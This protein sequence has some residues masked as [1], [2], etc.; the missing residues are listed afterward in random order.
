[1][2]DEDFIKGLHKKKKYK[3]NHQ[4]YIRDEPKIYWFKSKTMLH[5]KIV[6]NKCVIFRKKNNKVIDYKVI[7]LRC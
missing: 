6:V 2:I 7:D 4:P 1:M 5:N 3:T